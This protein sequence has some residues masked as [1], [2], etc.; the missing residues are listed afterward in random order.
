MITAV[1]YSPKVCIDYLN[2]R[3]GKVKIYV[4]RVFPHISTNG[5]YCNYNW[6]YEV[7]V[8]R[9]GRLQFLFK[10]CLRSVIN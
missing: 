5:I 8:L 6:L 1:K 3:T 2:R 7:T 9:W 4:R 10:E